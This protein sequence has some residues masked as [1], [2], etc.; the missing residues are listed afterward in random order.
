MKYI[1]KVLYS[2][3]T[4]NNAFTPSHSRVI[5]LIQTK[6]HWFLFVFNFRFFPILID[7]IFWTNKT[8]GL[9]QGSSSCKNQK[10]HFLPIP[11]FLFSLTSCRW[12]TLFFVFLTMSLFVKINRC[13]YAFYVLF[14]FL[15]GN[16]LYTCISFCAW[17]FFVVVQL[18]DSVWNSHWTACQFIETILV[19]TLI[20]Q[21]HSPLLCGVFQFIPLILCVSSSRSFPTFCSYG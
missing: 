5:H 6:L 7:F 10:C 2:K 19:L 16:I 11:S 1:I 9:F 17:L 13:T 12:S 15:K 4:R 8:L 20:P 14:F 3:V 21:W 18:S